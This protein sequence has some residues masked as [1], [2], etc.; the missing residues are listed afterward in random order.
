MGRQHITQINRLI[1]LYVVQ[2]P[3]KDLQNALDPVLFVSASYIAIPLPSKQ[4]TTNR[5]HNQVTQM[6]ETIEDSR[7]QVI[8]NSSEILFSVLSSDRQHNV[9]RVVS[10]IWHSRKSGADL[11]STHSQ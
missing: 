1:L 11:L 7:H 3:E 4:L 6:L 2:D 10:I 5:I 9:H 8:F